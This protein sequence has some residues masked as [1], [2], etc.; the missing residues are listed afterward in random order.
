[1][2]IGRVIRE[3]IEIYYTYLY[4]NYYIL[5]QLGC[6]GVQHAR[7]LTAMI[8]FD[9]YGVETTGCNQDDGNTRIT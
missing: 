5:Y 1:M 6:F 7:V 8:L 3:W 9:A 4:I 2:T